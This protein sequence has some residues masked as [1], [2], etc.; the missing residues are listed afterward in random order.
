L[1][2]KSYRQLSIHNSTNSTEFIKY[3]TQYDKLSQKSNLILEQ[4]IYL[5]GIALQEL[6]QLSILDQMLEITTNIEYRLSKQINLDTLLLSSSTIYFWKAVVFSRLGQQENAIK[7]FEKAS[8]IIRNS[9]FKKTI[10]FKESH[11]SSICGYE[12]KIKAPSYDTASFVQRKKFV[13]PQKTSDSPAY[14]NKQL[15]H[16]RYLDGTVKKGKYKKFVNDVITLKCEVI[17]T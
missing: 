10:Y 15:V 4:D 7:Y 3:F 14:T 13:N 12:E 11:Y 1:R 6:F 2:L 8:K 5:Y 16:V 17:K 9:K